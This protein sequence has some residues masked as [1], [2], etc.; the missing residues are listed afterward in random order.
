[1]HTEI[2]TSETLR[3]TWPAIV[4]PFSA[5]GQTFDQTSFERLLEFQLKS[6]VNGIVV[7]GSTGEGST[8]SSQEYREIMT[9]ACELVGKRAQVI[10]AI[11]GNSTQRAV[12]LAKFVDTLPVA[13]ILL[14]AP[15]YNK[16]QQ[17][18]MLEHFRQ[19]KQA[20]RLSIVAYNI[21][22]RSAVNILPITLA[23][24][25]SQ[26]LIIGVK[27]AS[28]SI[29]QMQEIRERCGAEFS[30]I[31]GE[32]SLVHVTMALGGRGVI[33]ASANIIPHKF[34]KIV[35][36][37]A[38]GDFSTSLAIQLEIMPLVRALFRETNPV[39][40]KAGLHALKLIDSARVREPLA[41]AES[42]TL[43]NLMALMPRV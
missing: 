22:G 34:V 18:G 20:T 42:A 43:E 35:N 21:P 25:F 5:D 32:D 6:G 30:L 9:F 37:A 29:E 26:Q 7:C 38:A 39:P 17:R 13:A 28:G 36:A 10:A 11:G 24:M 14:V 19:V 33:S 15:P 8:V 40:L 4:T 1:M 3:G 16:P 31:A 2:L 12:E 27:E 23:Q 41:D